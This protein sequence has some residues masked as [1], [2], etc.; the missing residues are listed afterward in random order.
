MAIAVGLAKLSNAAKFSPHDSEIEIFLMENNRAA[1][2]SIR[3]VGSGLL[4]GF[5]ENIFGKFM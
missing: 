3:D 2:V 5:R 1:K 4:E